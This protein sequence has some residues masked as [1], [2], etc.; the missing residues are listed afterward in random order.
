MNPGSVEMN[1]REKVSLS[2]HEDMNL[3][4]ET[5]RQ[6]AERGQVATDMLVSPGCSLLCEC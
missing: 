2:Q 5:A 6:A 4:E 1:G 3:K